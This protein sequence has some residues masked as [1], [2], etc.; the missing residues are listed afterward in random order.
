MNPCSLSGDNFSG[1][2]LVGKLREL[3]GIGFGMSV[4]VANVGEIATFMWVRLLHPRN[5]QQLFGGYMI[6]VA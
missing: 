2:G 1:S 6:Y 5:S 3:F 4:S